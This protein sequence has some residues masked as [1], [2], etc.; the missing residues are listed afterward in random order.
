MGLSAILFLVLLMQTSFKYSFKDQILST[1][2]LSTSLPTMM[3][4]RRMPKRPKSKNTLGS[5]FS[6]YVNHEMIISRQTRLM[7]PIFP[8]PF[9]RR[10]TLLFSELTCKN[11]SK[12]MISMS[13]MRPS[14]KVEGTSKIPAATSTFLKS[15]N[16]TKIKEYFFLALTSPSV[17]G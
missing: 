17:S 2:S 14:S 11:R 10:E 13:R 15:F 6:S 12:F 1:I 8:M 4:T 3:T 5:K 7:N 9:K 16:T